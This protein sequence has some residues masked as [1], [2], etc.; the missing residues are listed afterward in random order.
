V[1]AQFC[2][3]CGTP[4]PT[5][6]LDSVAAESASPDESA[7]RRDRIQMAL[8]PDYEV[9]LRVGSGGFA[10]VWA[11]LDRKLQRT[12]AVKVMHPVL[13]TSSELLER[14]QREAQAMAKLRHPGLIPIYS[15]GEHDG[16]AFYTMPLVDGETLRDVLAREGA[17]P[18]TDVRRILH[19]AAAA[20]AVVHD[21]GIVH[22]DIKPE[23]L[24]LEGKQRRVLV[25]DF[26][27]A[28]SV[29]GPP[30]ALTATGMI[31]GTPTYM[32]PEQATGSKEVDPRSDLY[33]LGVVG[34]EM[35]TGKPPFS[36]PSARELIMLH[37]T[38]PAPSLANLKAD[39]PWDLV[40]VI[41]R[42]LAKDPGQRWTNAGEL[43]T[44]LAGPRPP[45][46]LP[47]GRREKL[48]ATIALLGAIAGAVVW[49]PWRPRVELGPDVRPRQVTFRGDV[50]VPRLSPNGK[51]AAFLSGQRYWVLDVDRDTAWAVTDMQSNAGSCAAWGAW[52]PR[53]TADSRRLVMV[54]RS[55]TTMAPWVADV[56]DGR[57]R[58]F[59]Q[60]SLP[61]ALTEALTDS[62]A[63]RESLLV[64]YVASQDSG[65]SWLVVHRLGGASDRFPLPHAD[66]GEIVGANDGRPTDRSGRALLSR[67]LPG[68]TVPRLSLV[69]TRSGAFVSLDLPPRWVSK[70]REYTVPT[71]SFWSGDGRALYAPPVVGTGLWRFDLADGMKGTVSR[72]TRLLPQV[73]LGIRS[74]VEWCPEGEVAA[75]D[76]RNRLA[77]SRPECFVQ[78][79]LGRL[80]DG[81]SSQ[82]W[83]VQTA[84]PGAQ[85]LLYPTLAPGEQR[86]VYLAEANGAYG[87]FSSDL[88]SGPPRH[89]ATFTGRKVAGLRLAP[90]GR[91]AV[92]AVWDGSGWTLNLVDMR[93][94][95]THKL[96]GWSGS[97]FLNCHPFDWDPT[98]RRVFAADG[99]L[100]LAL[101]GVSGAT[102]TIRPPA[103]SPPFVQCPAASPDG[104]WL[105]VRAAGEGENHVLLLPLKGDGPRALE[106]TRAV[107][108]FPLGWRS[109][110][111]IV[112]LGQSVSA[113]SDD[114]WIY[115]AQGGR[116]RIGRLPGS[117]F[118]AA[119][120][121]D[122][123]AVVCAERH[124]VQ[125]LW[126]ADDFDPHF[127]P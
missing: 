19:D 25:M 64:S 126:I 63:A 84:R 31:F 81:H 114:V 120:S 1:D 11:A 44:A 2:P 28:K 6:A 121:P 53:W 9:Q 29:A 38:A 69:N 52:P 107:M 110:D 104:R 74:A 87:L 123:R 88:P 61:F 83:A 90:D 85:N 16:L 15:V 127:K 21:A 76:T 101:D 23:N 49:A 72:V 35:L 112:V 91:T 71:Q 41:D 12:V 56:P 105:A 39:I 95:A 117:C 7:E 98:S 70:A 48:L 42:C 46:I 94:G 103:E 59:R 65:R 4:T 18:P 113:D 33:S 50:C 54:L 60:E 62:L 32:S 8:G 102:D 96:P 78:A 24:M 77:V 100:M 125:D 80:G 116:R 20:L 118:G 55:D 93:S 14:F 106:G 122:R 92:V 109:S 99:N 57:A 47:S 40:A 66:Y 43:C 51:Y 58:P 119:L 86:L 67:S 97:I 73:D 26:G 5:R 124:V 111:Q 17:L 3:R 36:A 115:S 22:R 82:P 75:A 27:I 79:V 34:F 108:L 68:D 30:S 10:E 13:L 89:I 45:G 37:V